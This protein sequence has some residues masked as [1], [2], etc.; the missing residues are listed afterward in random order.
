MFQDYYQHH[1]AWQ[2]SSML[3]LSKYKDIIFTQYTKYWHDYL[4]LKQQMIVGLNYMWNALYMIVMYKCIEDLL[5]NIEVI[6][7]TM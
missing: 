4:G 2:L 3:V 1:T 7:W 5:I 6:V